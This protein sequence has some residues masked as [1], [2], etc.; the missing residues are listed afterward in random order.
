[1]AVV[2]RSPYPSGTLKT[3]ISCS[4]QRTRIRTFMESETQTE[5]HFLAIQKST[6]LPAGT[7]APDFTLKSAPNEMVTLSDFRGHPVIL[8]FY[9]GDWSPVCGDQAALYN[10]LLPEFEEL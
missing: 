1:M 7:A 8:F 10:E 2:C 5:Q 9:P 6:V 3:R 4:A